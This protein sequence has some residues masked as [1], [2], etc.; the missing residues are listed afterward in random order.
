MIAPGNAT[1]F[2]ELVESRL[3]WE[4]PGVR[5]RGL[6]IEANKVNTRRAEDTA[7]YTWENL[8]LAVELLAREKKSR[9]PIGVFAHVQRA[10]DL[11]LDTEVDVEE[12]IRT[13]MRYETALGDPQGWVVRFARA[14]GHHRKVLLD[15]WRQAVK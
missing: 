12:E 8:A 14:T 15:A 7:L 4:V 11:A 6:V 9:S 3:G 10:L 1:I 13:V 2:C 5:W